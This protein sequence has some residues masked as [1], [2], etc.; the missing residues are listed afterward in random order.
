MDGAAHGAARKCRVGQKSAR[1]AR[2]TPLFTTS[3][4]PESKTLVRGGR[5]D[6]LW[7]TPRKSLWAT[8]SS[9]PAV[10]LTGKTSLPAP[11]ALRCP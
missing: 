10:A 1:V 8:K 3:Y 5:R 2:P 4:M 9:P 6:R 7:Q 11:S